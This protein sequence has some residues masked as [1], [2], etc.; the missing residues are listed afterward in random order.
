M[1]VRRSGEGKVAGA[2]G[3]QRKKNGNGLEGK[4]G[5]GSGHGRCGREGCGQEA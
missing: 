2:A 3:M 5:E 4:V 1:S